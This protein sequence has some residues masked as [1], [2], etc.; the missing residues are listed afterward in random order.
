[1]NKSPQCNQQEEPDPCETE[2]KKVY[3]KFPKPGSW[4]S[5]SENT[6]T[7]LESLPEKKYI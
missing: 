6:G 5:I 1:M 7:M 2:L 4:P 3:S